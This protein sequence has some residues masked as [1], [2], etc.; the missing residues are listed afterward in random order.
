M[1]TKSKTTTIFLNV[2]LNLNK[3]KPVKM[4]NELIDAPELLGKAT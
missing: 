3:L 4:K 2:A 1:Q